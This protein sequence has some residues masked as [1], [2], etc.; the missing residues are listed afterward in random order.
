MPHLHHAESEI[1]TKIYTLRN[2][3]VMLDRDLAKLYEVETRTLKQAVSRNM[4]RFPGDFMF[5]LTVTEAESLVSQNVIPSMKYFG[6][7][8]PFAFT[9]QGVAMLSG[10]LKS[11]GAIDMN[12]HIMRAFVQMRRAVLSSP[13]NTELLERIKRIESEILV[14]KTI[15]DNKITSMSRDIYEIKETLNSFLD[16]HIVIKRPEDGEGNG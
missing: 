12:I 6:G 15:T 10:V 13:S 11:K 3:K 1:K 9:E 2:M 14:N 16:A 8:M 5:Q 4:N 7:A